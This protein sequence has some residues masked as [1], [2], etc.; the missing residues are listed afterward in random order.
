[1][2][3]AAT[4]HASPPPMWQVEQ[5]SIGD[6]VHFG[7]NRFAISDVE[8]VSG[9][10]VHDRYTDG[11][12]LGA[13]VFVALACVLAFGVFDGGLRTRF[14]LGTVLLSFLGFAAL[15]ELWKLNQQHY[16]E[17]K[18]T[19]RSGETLKFASANRADVEAFMT[20]LTLQ[21]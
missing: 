9:E 8:A 13:M 16:F 3:I 7:R 15:S 1:M 6:V 19:L 21:V 4:V 14:L 12:L 11:I 2:R 10:E 18:I 17:V 20:R 5:T